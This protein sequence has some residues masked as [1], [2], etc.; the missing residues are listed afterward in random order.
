LQLSIIIVN[1]NVKYFLEQCLHAVQNACAT[2]EAEIF[3]VD[4]NSKDGSKAYLMPLF[5]AVKF[6]WLDE[7]SGFAKAN[8]IA[9][10]QATG[11]F[12]LFLN[13][14]T[15]VAEDSFTSCMSF[16]KTTENCGAVGVRMIDGGGNFLK[17]S[18]RAFPSPLTS[19]YKILG[20]ARLFPTSKIFAKYH[21]G[22][23]SQHQNHEVDVLAGAFMMIP[24]NVL[25]ETGSFD[26]AFFMYGEDVDLSFRIQQAGYKNYY[27]ADTTIIHFKGESTKRGSLNYVRLF[28]KAMSQFVQKHYSGTRAKA[29]SLFIQIGIGLRAIIA[30]IANV[31]QKLGLPLLD[32]VLILSSF[33]I[34]KFLWNTIITKELNYS[35]NLLI[36]AFPIF[37]IIFLLASYYAGLYDVGYKKSQLSRS[38]FVASLILLSGYALLPES[39]RFSRGILLLG[40]LLAFSLMTLLR[41]FF[42]KKGFLLVSN[43]D[44][45]SKQTIVVAGNTDY[46]KI[47]QLIA[48]ANLPEKVLGRVTTLVSNQK[49]VLGT[50]QQLPHLI[51]KYA[52]NEIIFCRN[53]MSYKEIIKLIEHT[54][55]HVLNQFYA[56]GSNS[57]VG[58]NNKNFAG[59]IISPNKNYA[60]SW[61]G[62][63]RKKRL[64]DFCLASLFIITFPIHFILQKKPLPFFANCFAVLL[65]KKSWVGYATQKNELPKIKLGILTSTSLPVA[66]NELP[67]ESLQISDEWYATGYSVSADVKKITKGYKY[68]SF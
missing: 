58:S 38:T 62:N 54:P 59:N 12:I 25:N 41:L 43:T 67:E 1:Y 30:A 48:K 39:I 31:L 46:E 3:V 64:L 5:S 17:E 13:P 21:V 11:D 51:N 16:F 44:D 8:N 52:I 15:I 49:N 63:K 36:I 7:N 26:E 34:A 14:D 28:Y 2:I 37:T 33:W 6:I 66:L 61:A 47:I 56:S 53:G 23:L 68:L 4:N 18:K 35:S 55:K 19:L 9:V 50:T 42:I 45:Q 57:I 27:L 65:N 10:K 24:K 60:I 32:A 22:N 40:I 29:F 20:L